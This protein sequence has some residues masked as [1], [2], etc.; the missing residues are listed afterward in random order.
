MKVQVAKWGDGAAV[1]LPKAIVEALKLAPGLDIDVLVEGGE[2]RLRPLGP[3]PPTLAELPAGCD[4]IGW[5][6]QP[7]LEDGSRSSP[8][9]LTM[10]RPAQMSCDGRWRP[11]LGQI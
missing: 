6:N 4:R 8:P 11:R 7:P 10:S 1:R 9:D 5:E 2:V 3:R